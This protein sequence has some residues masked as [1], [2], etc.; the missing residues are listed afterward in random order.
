MKY[1]IHVLVVLLLFGY[2]VGKGQPRLLILEGKK[3]SLGTIHRGE[4]AEKKLTLRNAGTDTLVLD[5]VD[6]SCGCTGTIISA[7]RIPA[8]GS[9]S[10]LITFNSKNFS[11][12]IHKTVMIHSNSSDEPSQVVEFTAQVINEIV[13]TPSQFWFKDAAVGQLNKVVLTI[14]NNGSEELV[15]RSFRTALEGFVLHLPDA[16][17]KPGAEAQVTAEFTPKKALPFLAEGVFIATSNSHQP[18]IYIPIYGNSREF[19]FE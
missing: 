9:G 12:P 19:K 6:A 18:E 16:P 10:L 15:L 14:K 13:V 2:V 3:F 5:K 7:K 8:G 17:L 4:I 11:G 1:F